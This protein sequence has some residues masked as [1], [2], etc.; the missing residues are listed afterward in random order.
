MNRARLA[1][2]GLCNVRGI[3][4]A[5]LTAATGSATKGLS[6]RRVRRSVFHI[7]K[8]N[9]LCSMA[10]L[11]GANHAHINTAYFCYS[12]ELELYFLSHPNALH[13]RNLFTN[14]SM[15][16]TIFSSSQRWGGSDRGLQ[17]F[18]ICSQTRGPQARFAEELYRKRFAAYARW[19]ASLKKSDAA[20]EYRF[21]R[22]V[23]RKLKILDEKEF[24]GGVFVYATVRRGSVPKWKTLVLSRAS[25]GR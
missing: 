1:N 13:C 7:L 22:F 25:E 9:V 12:D 17:L 21:Y 3:R 16:M 19:K 11:T 20:R 6:E 2:I 14:S 8:N 23:V 5:T 10:T 24:G 4:I 18:G 15:G